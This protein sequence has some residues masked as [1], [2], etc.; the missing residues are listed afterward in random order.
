MIWMCKKN[1]YYKSV[2]D[3]EYIIS[4]IDYKKDKILYQN[5]KS[6][7]FYNFDVNIIN[8][9]LENIEQEH[10]RA[11]LKEKLQSEN[12]IDFKIIIKFNINTSNTSLVSNSGFSMF[13]YDANTS[14]SNKYGFHVKQSY[15]WHKV[16]IQKRKN[17]LYVY[18]QDI[19]NLYKKGNVIKTQL[20]LVKELFPRHIIQNFADYKHNIYSVKEHNNISILF[21]D[22]SDFTTICDTMKPIDVINM[23][24]QYFSKL[25][26]LCNL[27]NLQKIDTCGDCYIV[28]G[29]LINIDDDG[30]K[31]VNKSSTNITNDCINIMNFAIDAISLTE[32]NISV[33]IGIHIGN[34]A[35]GIIGKKVPKF[36]IIGDTVNVAARMQQ[37][38]KKNEII[39][40][41]EFYQKVNNYYEW[42]QFGKVSIK[43]KGEQYVY[44]CNYNNTNLILK[45]ISEDSINLFCKLL[46]NMI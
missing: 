21:L 38:A 39:S 37:I 28:A 34:C 25:D 14:I 27:H 13:T 26:K 17:C 8:Y 18:Q 24:D 9:I 32:K 19:T 16:N 45:T 10:Q 42:D 3:D 22:I 40:S 44:R 1:K 20:E 35:S 15:I 33:K 30:Y 31:N 2:I 12:D 43:G 29:G 11:V 36:T 4:I 6:L 7:L 23:L 46:N 41:Y 5:S